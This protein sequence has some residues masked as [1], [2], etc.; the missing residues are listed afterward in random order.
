MKRMARV[1]RSI[2]RMAIYLTLVFAIFIGVNR[3]LGT[4]SFELFRPFVNEHGFNALG[5]IVGLSLAAI[6]A[7]L[8]AL[9]WRITSKLLGLRSEED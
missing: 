2:V 9:V 6:L 8:V 1:V 5:Y 4:A 7:S 3:W